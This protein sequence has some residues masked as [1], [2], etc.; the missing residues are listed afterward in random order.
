[1]RGGELEK[2]A[3]I[4][5]RNVGTLRADDHHGDSQPHL[6]INRYVWHQ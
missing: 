3:E 2:E 1:M 5:E 6:F 4:D